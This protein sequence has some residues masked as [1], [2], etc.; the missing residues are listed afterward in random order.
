MSQ[1]H[2][3]SNLNLNNDQL[4]LIYDIIDN[5]SVGHYILQFCGKNIIPDK[6]KTRVL[7]TNEIDFKC[8]YNFI[9]AL[10][11]KKF[12]TLKNKKIITNFSQFTK[13]QIGKIIEL[14][15]I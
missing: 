7:N 13:R 15:L 6:F 1:V 8:I 5:D 4:N 11:T 12:R 2:I 3:K 9:Y 14:K 10:N